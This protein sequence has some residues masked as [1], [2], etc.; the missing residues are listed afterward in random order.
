M[1]SLPRALIPVLLLARLAVAES[2]T[3]ASACA[4]SIRGRLGGADPGDVCT[5]LLAGSGVGAAANVDLL[6]DVETQDLGDGGEALV[7]RRKAGGD[8]LSSRPSF[9]FVREGDRWALA[10]DARGADARY[11]TDRPKVNRRYQIERVVEANVPG[12]YRK[13]EVETWFWNGSSYARAFTRVSIQGAKE[14]KL[15]GDKMLWNPETEETYRGAGVSW[16]YEVKP[17]DTLSTI[18]KK[19]G[20]GAAELSRQNGI[21][22]TTTLRIGQKLRYE[23]WKVNA[24]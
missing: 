23:S 7:F 6:F 12:L 16:T 19:Q 17:G 24:R 11:A 20:V 22:A 13:R 4:E 1:S 9:H 2:D 15:N 18:S 5:V 21:T 10:F 3:G 8:A 14:A